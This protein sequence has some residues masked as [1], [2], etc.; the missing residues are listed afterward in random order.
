M[1][2]HWVC[3]VC[4]GARLIRLDFLKDSGSKFYWSL[5]IISVCIVT[6]RGVDWECQPHRNITA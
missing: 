2:G 1:L 6:Q 3:L 4:L 5:N